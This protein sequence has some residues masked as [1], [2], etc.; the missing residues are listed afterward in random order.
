M[1]LLPPEN[2]KLSLMGAFIAY[3]IGKIMLRLLT[4]GRYPPEN[5]P[6]NAA[7]VALSPWCILGTVLTLLYS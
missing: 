4:L 2:H 6:H 7:L 3:P 1:K 5:K